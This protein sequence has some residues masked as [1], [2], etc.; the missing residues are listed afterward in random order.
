MLYKLITHLNLFN[1]PG[2]L[3]KKSFLK[4]NPVSKLF[5]AFVITGLLWAGPLKAQNALKLF[6]FDCGHLEFD[7]IEAYGL[8]DDETDIRQLAVP[9]YLIQHEDGLLLW[10][11]GLPPVFAETDGWQEIEGYEGSYA[12]LDQTFTSQLKELGFTYADIDYA[13]FSHTHFDHMGAANELNGSFI[14]MQQS[15]YE[16]AYADTV[17]ATGFEPSTYD[18]LQDAEFI[19]IDGD[20]DVFGDGSVR[21]LSTPGHTPGHQSLFVDLAEYGPVILSGDLYHFRFNRKHRRY[22][23]FNTDGAATLESM[24]RV[25][26]LIEETGATLWI[27]HDLELFEEL[28]YA[29]RFYE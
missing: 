22:P 20:Y 5:H 2:K 1:S 12:R 6:L 17:T 23:V 13:A 10:D 11:A 28:K 9:C 4:R 25:E 7:S 14:I 21:I 8:G 15:E 24:N 16:A 26:R 3:N 27:Q 19:V 18:Q 29:S